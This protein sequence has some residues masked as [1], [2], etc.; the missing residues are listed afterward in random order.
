MWIR[1]VSGGCLAFVRHAAK[2]GSIEMHGGLFI[3]FANS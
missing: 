3:P 2:L 1:Q